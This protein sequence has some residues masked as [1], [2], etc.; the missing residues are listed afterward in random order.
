MPHSALHPEPLHPLAPSIASKLRLLAEILRAG[1]PHPITFVWEEPG[2]Y[3]GDHATKMCYS[4]D[5]WA[6][7]AHVAATIEEPGLNEI[8]RVRKRRRELMRYA[9]ALDADKFV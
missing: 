2:R 5:A 8:E 3:A 6:V 9:D 1:E 4:L 7:L